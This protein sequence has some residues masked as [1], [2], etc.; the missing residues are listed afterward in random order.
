[1]ANVRSSNSWYIDTQ[2]ATAS[3]DLIVKNISVL[4]AIVTA[5][6]AS[7]RL[8]LS[9]ASSNNLKLDL[10]V[11]SIN[12]STSGDSKTFDFSNAPIIFPNGVVVSTLTTCVATLIT[13][14]MGK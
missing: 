13:K 3:D 1:M 9:D 8:V 10:R 6:G 12:G 7:G 4:G 11:A 2:H 5:T 14:D